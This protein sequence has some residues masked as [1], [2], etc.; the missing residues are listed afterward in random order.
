MIRLTV[1]QAYN[2]LMIQ[3]YLKNIVMNMTGIPISHMKFCKE[4]T[5]QT[6]QLYGGIVTNYVYDK[7]GNQTREN[8]D[9]EGNKKLYRYDPFNRLVSV[10]KKTGNADYVTMQKNYYN[11]DDARV[12]SCTGNTETDYFYQ[13]GKLSY[14]VNEADNSI[15]RY[16]YGGN[17]GVIVREESSNCCFYTKDI[18]GSTMSLLSETGEPLVTYDYDDYGITK[19]KTA[20]ANTSGI[21]IDNEICYSGGVYDIETSLYYPNA[22]YY[23]PYRG[24]FL[25]QDSYRG[26]LDDE[27]TW[28]LY[29][30]CANNPVNYVDPSGHAAYEMIYESSDV[31]MK[32]LQYLGI[33]GFAISIKDEL[34][35]CGTMI[36]DFVKDGANACKDAIVDYYSKFDGVVF[37]KPTEPTFPVLQQEQSIAKPQAGPG[38]EPTPPKKNNMSKKPDKA[39]KLQKRGERRKAP[40]VVK[41]VDKG[42][43]GGKDHVHFKN[44]TAMNNY[45]TIHDKHKGIPK[46][47]EKI[48]KWLEGHNWEWKIKQ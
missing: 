42:K 29:A 38:P 47:T 9:T 44:G 2:I 32:V 3:E 11:G 35:E 28:N 39:N 8:A 25:T 4:V 13:Q 48:R 14:T 46:I 24:V 10:E 30:Y 21:G 43:N 18:K 36:I 6:V 41:R 33:A 20:A 37:S 26:T 45:G 22:R 7:S 19:R 27:I 12:Y 15:S 31:L 23:S 1:L 17:N 5:K 34:K 16:L 40:K